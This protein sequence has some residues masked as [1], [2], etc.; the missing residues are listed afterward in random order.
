MNRITTILYG[1]SGRIFTGKENKRVSMPLGLFL[2]SLLLGLSYLSEIAS[3]DIFFYHLRPGTDMYTFYGQAL[4]TWLFPRLVTGHNLPFYS[5]IFLAKMFSLLGGANLLWVRAVQV[6]FCAVSVV[7]IYFLA[8]KVFGQ[9][10]AVAA[11][12]IALLYGRFYI[13]AGVILSETLAVLLA[14][15]FLLLFLNFLEKRSYRYLVFASLFFALLVLVRLKMLITGVFLAG[16]ILWHFRAEKKAV[17]GFLS[18]FVLVVLL[19]AGPQ[20]IGQSF[21]GAGKLF[22]LCNSK[23]A[24]PLLTEKAAPAL[25]GL[26]AG[27]GHSLQSAA[28]ARAARFIIKSPEKFLKLL[29]GKVVLFFSAGRT[30]FDNFPPQYYWRISRTLRFCPLGWG[31]IM[32]LGLLG[33]FYFFRNPRCRVLYI[34]LGGYLLSVFAF[35]IADRYRLLTEP[36][37]IIFAAGFLTEIFFRRME[38]ALLL[39]YL[40]VFCVLL[41]LINY[42]RVEKKVFVL[43]HPHGICFSIR[44]GVLIRDGLG[45]LTDINY[46]AEFSSSKERVIKKLIVDRPPAEFRQAILLID[47]YFLKGFNI[48]IAVNGRGLKEQWSFPNMKFPYLG[49]IQIPLPLEYLKKGENVFAV[50]TATPGKAFIFIDRRYDYNRSAFYSPQKGLSYDDLGSFSVLG[51]GEY[52]IALELLK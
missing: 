51:D 40:G 26:K 9:H 15:T 14:L 36:L 39:R 31:L 16:F 52:R 44:G 3:K 11:G 23:Y 18:V 34:F 24:G 47:G 35:Q 13:Y 50:G 37:F 8:K 48:S 38:R 4:R 45:K 17:F 33:I 43:V 30:V 19:I 21:R 10:A 32:P 25:S 49:T 2:L 12:I 27:K 6:L 1:L 29:F 22:L 42:S 20:R 41:L 5:H 7:L 28:Y 46:K